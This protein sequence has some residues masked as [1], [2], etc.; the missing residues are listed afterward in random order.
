MDMNSKNILT[1]SLDS[2]W[3]YDTLELSLKWNGHAN[4]E[5]WYSNIGF[6]V[7]GKSVAESTVI[8]EFVI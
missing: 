4:T 5:I 6:S 3:F 7:S 8:Y 2:D 1:T